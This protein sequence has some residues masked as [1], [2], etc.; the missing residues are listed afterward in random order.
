VFRAIGLAGGRTTGGDQLSLAIRIHPPFWQQPWF[1]PVMAAAGVG[2][3]ATSV[4]V[5][6]RQ[7]SKRALEQLRFQ[8][9]LEKDRSRIA[10]DMHDDLGSRVTFINMSAAIAH[11]DIAHAP[12]NAR[13]HLAKMT[14]S[15]RDLVVAMDDLVWAVDPAHD[16]LDHLGSYLTR[17]SDE[18]FRDSQARCRLDIPPVLPAVPLGAD[19]RH[20]IA[21]AVK[22]AFHNILRHA[23][24]CEVFFALEFEGGEIRISIRD[25]GV[26]FDLANGERGHGLDNL[27]NRFKEIGGLCRISSSPGKGTSIV[28]SCR[29]KQNHRP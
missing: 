22:E 24:T 6:H 27:A 9:A 14:Q 18:M 2:L 3:L 8:N 10:R 28:L 21:L 29:A 19:A 25:T 4:L 15:A 20:H 13:R 5:V 26:G 7:R 16:T 17:L 23:G 1:W 12:E 11:R